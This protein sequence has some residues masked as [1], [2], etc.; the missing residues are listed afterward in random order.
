MIS[1]L[2]YPPLRLHA[3]LAV[4]L[5]VFT[6]CQTTEP[7]ANLEAPLEKLDIISDVPVQPVVAAGLRLDEALRYLGSGL[8]EADSARLKALSEKEHTPAVAEEVQAILDPY[9]LAAVNINPEAR[10]KVM[11]GPA[12]ANLQQ[13]GWKSFLIKVHN[14]SGTRAPIEWESPNAEPRLHVST[15][16]PEPKPEN[17]IS[18]GEAANRYLELSFYESRPLTTALSGIPVEYKVLQ[19]YTDEVGPREAK[20][21]FHVGQGSQDVG[22]RNAVTVFFDCKP[23]VKV[24]LQVKDHDGGPAMASF[25]IRDNVQRL[26]DTS[27]KA[28]AMPLDYRQTRALNEPWARPGLSAQPLVGVYPLPSRRITTVSDYPD[29][30]FHP[31]VYRAD[32]EFVYLPP[33]T[34]DVTWTRGPEYLAHSRTITVPEGVKE[35]TERFQL[36]RWISMKDKGFFSADHH[37]HAGGCSHYESPEAGVRPEAMLRQAQGEDLDVSCVLT[38]G[39][40]WYHQKTFFEGEVHKLS[41]PENIMRY[42]VEVSGFPS[43]HA[44]HLC[45]LRLKEDDYPGTTLIEEWPSWTLPVLQWGK[46]QGGVV[47][48]S[49]SGW[50]LAPES[51]TEEIPNYVM[52]KFDGI[53]ANEYIVTATHDAVD[54]ISAGD[55]PLHMELNIW[56]HVLNSGF[57]TAISGETDFPCIFDDRIGMARSYTRLGKLDFDS[58]AEKIKEGANYVSDG[59]SHLYNFKVEGNELGQNKNEVRLDGA[60]DVTVTATA[61]AWLPEV[62]DDAGKKIAESGFMGRPYWH[63]EKARIGQS[64][65]VAVELIV[66]GYPVQTQEI[67]ADG[68][69]HEVSFTHAV[70]HSSWVALRITATAHTNPIYVLVGDQPIRASRRSAEWCRAA[71]DQCWKMKETQIRKEDKPAAIAAYDHARRAYDVAIAESIDDRPPA[72]RK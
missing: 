10:V 51:H 71:V 50:G 69:E 52:A 27:E 19:V 37:V 35:H 16:R 6:G 25:I 48:Y 65:K 58:F 26:V 56:Y 59:R 11:R 66:N 18:P 33:G 2:N 54:F 45:L 67:V 30:F 22:Y 15:G 7:R 17:L 9:C 8:S 39:P 31:Q 47:G 46:E 1:C 12:D 64:R 53:G 43:S 36:E 68:G 24:Q 38:W 49:H 14:E 5:L 55:T 41:T 40:C 57:R 63:V 3:L 61:A 20:L 4:C 60:R 72:P 34:Y 23:S 42:D 29:F 32:G 44:G 21:G 13:G 28:N 70:H 62:Q